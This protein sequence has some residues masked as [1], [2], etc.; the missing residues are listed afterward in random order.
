MKPHPTY[1]YG[2]PV[3]QIHEHKTNKW[4]WMIELEGGILFKNQ[5]KK[6][7]KPPDDSVITGESLLTAVDYGAGDPTTTLRFGHTNPQSQPVFVADVVMTTGK[8]TISDPRSHLIE[9]GEHVQDVIEAPS[10][11]LPPDPSEER[12]A[13][14]PTTP[15]D[16]TEEEE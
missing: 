9:E 10:E 12:V 5:D 3:V 4:E 7:T 16:A 6:R 14:G 8:W 11:T 13:D 2:R 15:E 1:Y